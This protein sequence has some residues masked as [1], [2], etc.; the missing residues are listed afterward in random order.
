MK[1][2]FCLFIGSVFALRITK[3]LISHGYICDRSHLFPIIVWCLLVIPWLFVVDQAPL[4]MWFM[5]FVQ[6]FGP[7]IFFEII[8]YRRR[9]QFHEETLRFFD[10][11]LMGVR[12]GNSIREVLRGILMEEKFGFHTREISAAVLQEDSSV[13]QIQTPDFRL[14]AI[15][16]HKV[17][18]SGGKVAERIAAL[19]R[20]YR[21]LERFRRKSR[22]A[23]QSVNAQIVV[24][25][26]LY[27]GL[28]VLRFTEDREIFRSPWFFTSLFFIFSGIFVIQMMKRSFKW[29]I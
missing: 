1:L 17:L 3:K 22:L 26:V 7:M 8:K 24:I 29:R 12:A 23:T 10:H 16:I 28:L 20:K 2:M 18:H 27:V 6:F 11:L 21:M 14:R 25:L 9:S 4:I 5:C 19:R 15:E 13:S